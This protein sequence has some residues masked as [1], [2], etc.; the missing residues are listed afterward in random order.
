MIQDTVA[1]LRMLFQE[2]FIDGNIV[3]D[4]QAHLHEFRSVIS[5]PVGWV[6]LVEIFSTEELDKRDQFE[7]GDPVIPMLEEL[8]RLT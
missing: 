6:I 4:V 2:T 1:K 7:V 8:A 3:T 5:M